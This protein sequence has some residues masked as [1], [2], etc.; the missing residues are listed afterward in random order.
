MFISEHP[1]THNGD[2]RVNQMEATQCIAAELTPASF[3][4]SS[5]AQGPNSLI[6]Y[7][8]PI[9]KKVKNVKSSPNLNRPL[10]RSRTSVHPKF[11]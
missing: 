3:P 10:F 1:G 6:M 4:S 7:V 9:E 2:K 8:K 11:C 5:P